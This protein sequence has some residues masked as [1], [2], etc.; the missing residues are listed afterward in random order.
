[1]VV[2]HG[3]LASVLPER[4]NL[5]FFAS[6]V[7][8]SQETRESEYQREIELLSE[9]PREAHGVYFSS[10]AALQGTSRYLE[11]KREME[12]RVKEH[13]DTSTI[14]RIGNIN[15]GNNPHTLINYLRAHP[16]AEIRD[17]YRY[18]V[19]KEEFLYWVDQI[20]EW[21]CEL[22]IPGHRMKVKEIFDEYVAIYPR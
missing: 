6:G 18:V 1:M 13:F 21:T 10:I 8:N 14:V 22:T 3:D 5:L 17:E 12:G 11:H 20:P 9:Q 16:D 7:S 19:T 15:F 4:E 2:G